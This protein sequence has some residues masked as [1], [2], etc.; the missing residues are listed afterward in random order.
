MRILI[1]MLRICMYLV[2]YISR[3]GHKNRL[4][5]VLFVLSG[6][7]YRLMGGDPGRMINIAKY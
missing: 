2:Q 1:G 4:R 7:C 5:I 6:I 3:G